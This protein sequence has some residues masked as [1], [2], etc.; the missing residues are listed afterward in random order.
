ME[1]TEHS[2]E[3]LKEQEGGEMSGNQK[4]FALF[5]LHP[6]FWVGLGLLIHLAF[7]ISASRTGWFNLFFSGSALHLCCRGMDF[8]QVPNGAYSYIHGGP[9]NATAVAGAQ[10]FGIGFPAS[11]PNVYHPLFTLV[12]GSFLTLFSPASSFYVW[13]FSKLLVYLAV[14]FYFY[15]NFKESKYIGLALFLSLINSTQYLEIEISQFQFALNIFLFLLL[16]RLIKHE[17]SEFNGILYFL[18]LTVKPIGLLWIPVFLFKR[19]YKTVLIGVGLFIA[20]T[21]IFL[22]NGSG[23]YYTKNLWDNFFNPNLSG[24]IQIFTLEAFLRYSTQ[25]PESFL[26]TL[27]MLCLVLVVYLSAFRRISLVTGIFLAIAYY[28]LFYGL[29]FEYH[30][31]TLIP[32][33]AVC[34]VTRPEFQRLSSRICIIL[35]SLPNAMF[36]LNI[37]ASWDFTLGAFH[38]RDTVVMDHFLGLD[39]T[40]LGWQISVLSRIVP[41]ILLTFFVL[42]PHIFPIFQDTKALIY[43]IIRVNRDLNVPG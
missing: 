26:S 39:P 43:D 33:L 5:T 14:L 38:A 23:L 18:T 4:T 27:K 6:L 31:T 19:Q 20:I 16:I 24:P 17:Q 7:Y 30:Y 13:M 2:S 22:L 8:Y 41:L 37:L 1:T 34:L 32:I 25:F 3:E 36:L 35:I 40:V 12:L 42:K 29:V 9:L 10:I 15:R 28:L 11:N 21:G